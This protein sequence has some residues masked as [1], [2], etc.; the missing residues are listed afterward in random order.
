MNE[1]NLPE[2]G[3]WRHYKYDP[4]Q[5]WD[6]HAYVATH[7]SLDTD[8]DLLRVAYLPLYYETS[9]LRVAKDCSISLG[10]WNS[11]VEWRGESV[12]RYTRITDP[13]T[14]EKLRVREQEMY[15]T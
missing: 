8:T 9:Y 5:G 4:E 14:I 13:E 7:F 3:F 11:M 2:L 1:Q 10:R 15:G 6:H 12:P